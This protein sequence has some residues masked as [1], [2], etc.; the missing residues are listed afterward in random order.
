MERMSLKIVVCIAII[1]AISICC[2]GV[3]FAGNNAGEAA[4]SSRDQALIKDLM[5]DVKLA[6][7]SGDERLVAKLLLDMVKRNPKIAGKIVQSFMAMQSDTKAKPNASIDTAAII[8]NIVA[9][10]QEKKGNEAVIAAVL[11][12]VTPASGGAMPA[13]NK[14]KSF[15]TLPPLLPPAGQQGGGGD[16]VLKDNPG[17]AGA[18]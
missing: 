13:T 9:N 2:Y 4:L 3:A 6:A 18:N 11:A 16:A 15:S 8:N 10:L 1:T 12:S 7:S 14:Q 5:Q 17:Q